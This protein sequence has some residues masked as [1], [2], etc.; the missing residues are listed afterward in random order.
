MD[1]IL[2]A[3]RVCNGTYGKVYLDGEW[4]NNANECTADVEIDQKEIT[5]C[6]SEW[7][8]YKNGAKKGSGTIKGYK[9]TSKMIE[10]GFKGFEVLTTLEDPEAYGYERI[11][12]KNCKASKINLVNFKGGE[13][14]EEETPFT[15]VG[16]EL[17]DP[18]EIN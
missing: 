14:V 15:F 11:R 18:I 7:T 9:I 17:V 3:S 2:D 1:E 4:Q 8:G 12:L 16:Y 10:R 5:P 13:V 6:G